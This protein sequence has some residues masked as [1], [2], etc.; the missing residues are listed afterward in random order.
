MAASE[1]C[2]WEAPGFA[3]LSWEILKFQ[4][5]LT[6][7]V[8]KAPKTMRFMIFVQIDNSGRHPRFADDLAARALP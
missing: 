4:N 6:F 7:S 3:A 1:R 8:K 2:C 5:I